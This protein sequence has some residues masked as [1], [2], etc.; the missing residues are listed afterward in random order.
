MSIDVL[1]NP[2][3]AGSFKLVPAGSHPAICFRVLDLGT[4]VSTFQGE[5]KEQHKVLISFEVHD[6]DCQ[7]DDGRPMT[8]HQRY[9]WSMHEKAT[10]RK[11]LEAWRA[12]P[13]TAADFNKM[14]GFSIRKLL[15][16]PCMLTVVHNVSGERSYANIGSIG[17]L[18]KGL[19]VGALVN[20]TAYLSLSAST[21]D[22]A[23]F[24]KL[25]DGLKETI[26]ASP[27]YRRLSGANGDATG[28]EDQDDHHD[29]GRSSYQAPI[30]SEIPF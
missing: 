16:V 23:V 17:K 5:R 28:A 1:P 25:A 27:E 21:F 14:G 30:D 18:H 19:K 7:M 24:D 4:Q 2:G 13:F 15:G 6:E 11:H 3:E 22:R 26:K 10:L 29:Q 8:M 20:E 9:T 12:A